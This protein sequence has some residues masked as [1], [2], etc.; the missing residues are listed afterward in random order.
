MLAGG[1]QVFQKNTF[2]ARSTSGKLRDT[3]RNMRKGV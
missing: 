1:F 3:E 2:D